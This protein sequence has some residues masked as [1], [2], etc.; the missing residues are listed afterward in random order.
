MYALIVTAKRNEIDPRSWLAGVFARIA[1]H[2]ASRLADLLLWNWKSETQAARPGSRTARQFVTG[3][4][5]R[6]RPVADLRRATISS[7]TPGSAGVVVSPKF[8]KSLAAILLRMRRRI[9]PARFFGR[10]GVHWMLS[11]VAMA[12]MRAHP[13]DD[14]LAQFL[15]LRPVGL[16]RDIGEEALA[17]DL[18]REPDHRRMRA[19]RRLQ[20]D[21]AEPVAGDIDDVIDPP[22]DPVI[23]ILVAPGAIAG[24][25]VPGIGGK[26]R[27]HEALVVVQDR[28]GLGRP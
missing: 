13:G 22:G 5:R 15:S 20:L 18:M 21:C 19:D 2:P 12:P 8:S 10:A 17:L 14:L 3:G 27:A 24:E 7:T 6:H 28:P 25:K 26:I 23:T 11:N 9:L 16:E 4:A 1:D